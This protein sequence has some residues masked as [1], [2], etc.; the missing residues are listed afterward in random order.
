M[1]PRDCGRAVATG[2]SQWFLLLAHGALLCVL[3]WTLQWTRGV[4]SQPTLQ[5]IVLAWLG[6]VAVSYA[7]CTVRLS[8]AGPP[9]LVATFLALLV[10]WTSF[11]LA[12]KPGLIHAEH[13]A[14]MRW[15]D[16]AVQPLPWL[17]LGLAVVAAWPA[18]SGAR[19]RERAFAVLAAGFFVCVFAARVLTP[20][21]S[22][23]PLIDV[24]TISTDGAD[25]LLHGRN[26]YSQE[27]RDLYHGV[28]AY[29]PRF[30]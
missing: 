21:A 7:L 22:P 15:L 9:A 25:H 30:Y 12:K 5:W 14:A 16:A 19:A 3:G 27:Y 20:I 28:Y 18:T 4:L 6:A 13:A 1:S 24:F 11:A 8:A 10:A 23:S 2:A 29:P 17:A 26:P